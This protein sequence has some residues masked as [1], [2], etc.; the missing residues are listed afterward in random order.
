[1]E[2]SAPRQTL[3]PLI[4]ADL[5]AAVKLAT[6]AIEGF[7]GRF[8]REWLAGMR[9]KLGLRTALDEDVGL[10]R[11]WLA[12][13]HGQSVDF[14]LAFRSLGEAAAGNAGPREMFSDSGAYDDWAT[15]W[16]LRLEQEPGD[17]TARRNFMAGVNPSVIPRNHRVEAAIEAAVTTGFRTF[18]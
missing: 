2:L 17:A 11:D 5:D 6:D 14:T 8:E 9:A 4:D 3:L 10:V 7:S 1:M 16:R 15:H 13:L 12:L 18:S